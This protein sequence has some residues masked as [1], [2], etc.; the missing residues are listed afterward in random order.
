MSKEKRYNSFKNASNSKRVRH[1]N[2]E[3]VVI[4]ESESEKE[5]E[6]TYISDKSESDTSEIESDSEEK[7]EEESKEKNKIRSFVWAHFEKFMDDKGILWVK[8][9]YCR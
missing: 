4:E 3:K 7:N 6:E 9:K 2:Y 1:N 8:C 5:S